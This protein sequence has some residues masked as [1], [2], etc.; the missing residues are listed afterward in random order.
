MDAVV[1]IE[2]KVMGVIAEVLRRDAERINPRASFEELGFDS[3]D[4]FELVIKV[5]DIFLIEISD[6][7]AER[8]LSIEDVVDLVGRKGARPTQVM[9]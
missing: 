7:E 9:Y 4:H 5:E 6:D 2:Q 1:D 8:L 3:M